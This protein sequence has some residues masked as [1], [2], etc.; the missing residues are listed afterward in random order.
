M[1]EPQVN[2]NLC[3]SVNHLPNEILS[4]IF[5]KLGIYS[6]FARIVCNLWYSLIS[7]NKRYLGIQG[8]ILINMSDFHCLKYIADNGYPLPT[9][10][11]FCETLMFKLGKSNSFK[12][13]KWFLDYGYNVITIDF[14]NGAAQCGH[15]NML[16][17][18]VFENVNFN[19]ETC[20]FATKSGNLEILQRL[21]SLNTPWDD[22]TCHMA[23]H[24]G[25]F[26]ILKWARENGCPW[27]RRTCNAAAYKNNFEI[28]KWAR[29]NGCEWN[30]WATANAANG[31]NMEMLKWLR[32][33]GCPWD[34]NLFECAAEQGHLQIIKWAHENNCPWNDEIA[35]HAASRGHL[36][37]IK[38]TI[39]LG[40]QMNQKV[41]NQA[42]NNGHNHI[43]I[44]ALQNG[45]VFDEKICEYVIKNGDFDFFKFLEKNNFPWDAQKCLL[46]AAKNGHLPLI[47]EI[48]SKNHSWNEDV[49]YL[50][51]QNNH[52]AIVEWACKHKYLFNFTRICEIV[53]S[54]GNIL[55][56]RLMKQYNYLPIGQDFSSQ[57]I[58]NRINKYIMK[59]KYPH[60]LRYALKHEIICPTLKLYR[61]IIKYNRYLISNVG[62]DIDS[63]TIRQKIQ[64]GA[65]NY[66]KKHDLPLRSID[67][68]CRASVTAKRFDIFQWLIENDYP[69]PILEYN[70]IIKN[71]DRNTRLWYFARNV[72]PIGK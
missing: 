58:N 21:R 9:N 6:L 4:L 68:L 63:K 44:W 48:L 34:K 22:K 35:E 14:A 40:F 43:L 2:Y 46:E 36:E 64:I 15:M 54:T 37:I 28:L 16:N 60:V 50:A 52:I 41:W 12:E 32:E 24:C 51:A 66:A 49:C 1:T 53:F 25:H 55:I 59:S 33:N 71:L 3:D 27:N 70:D 19:T 62:A 38:W 72:H 7:F 42:A 30:E 47:K 39:K 11:K 67:G 69:M 13:I 57:K 29:D 10:Q 23:A 18:A 5:G 31:G 8:D 17:L 65:L 20:K 56:L 26:H 45:Y 61:Q